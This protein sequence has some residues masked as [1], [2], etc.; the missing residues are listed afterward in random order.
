MKPDKILLDHGSGGAMSHQLI[1]ETL[2]PAFCNPILSQ[3]HDGAI[4]E[5]REGRI[6]FSTDTF[7]VDPIFFPVAALGIWPS[8]AL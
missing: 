4:I 6:A 2:L 1:T 8:T 3:L 5:V 7:V